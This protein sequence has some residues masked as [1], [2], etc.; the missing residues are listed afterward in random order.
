MF[1]WWYV[2]AWTAGL[3]AILACGDLWTGH[4]AG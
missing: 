3:A 1:A 2:A 4:G